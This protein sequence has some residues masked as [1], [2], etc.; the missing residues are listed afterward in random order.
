[1][2]II[3]HDAK[4]R[5]H[6]RWLLNTL[7]GP[8]N[9]PNGIEINWLHVFISGILAIHLIIAYTATVLCG[10]FMDTIWHPEMA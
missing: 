2:T 5:D 9:I 10:S 4:Q 3:T 7:N 1:M 8:K 6:Y